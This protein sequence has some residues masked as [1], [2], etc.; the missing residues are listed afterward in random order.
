MAVYIA[1]CRVAPLRGTGAALSPFN[2]FLNSSRSRTLALRM[3]RH[4]ENAQKVAEYLQ[5]HPQVVQVKY[6]GL[7]SHPEHDLA[8]RYMS[9]KPAGIL[10]GIKGG[11]G[12]GCEIYRCI[13]IDCASCQYW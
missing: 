8:V 5:N 12:S 6:A 11:A 10:F 3:E 9:G 1:R 4:T 13:E 2:A 7:T